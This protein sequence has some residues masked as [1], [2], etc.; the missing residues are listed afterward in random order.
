[1]IGVVLCSI[2]L[3]ANFIIQKLDYIRFPYGLV[4]IFAC[5]L[6][7]LIFILIGSGFHYLFLQRWSQ[8]E[9]LISTTILFFLFIATSY[10]NVLNRSIGSMYSAY[11]FSLI[12]FWIIFLIRSQ[13]VK[14]NLIRLIS[15]ISYPLYLVHRIPGYVL[16]TI[17]INNGASP[18][19]AIIITVMLITTLAYTVY[20][21]IEK[22]FYSYGK[23]IV[24]Y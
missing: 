10:H 1:M 17:L 14:F 5:T 12:L 7:C 16:L 6:P 15:K 9:F 21:F 19:S 20:V 13:L 24:Q 8:K 22:P 11:F 2:S 4:F 23:K 3:L 18:I